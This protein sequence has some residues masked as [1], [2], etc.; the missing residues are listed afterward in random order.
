MQARP[1]SSQPALVE[2]L[3]ENNWH[4]FNANGNEE[5]ACKLHSCPCDFPICVAYPDIPKWFL[6]QWSLMNLEDMCT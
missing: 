2:T 1:G 4:Q 3:A 6:P 5:I